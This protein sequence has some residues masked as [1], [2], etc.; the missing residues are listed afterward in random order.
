MILNP[1]LI[2]TT[3]SIW[4][5]IDQLPQGNNNLENTNKGQCHKYQGQ[6]ILP[7]NTINLFDNIYL[8]TKDY[9]PDNII[10]AVNKVGA[11]AQ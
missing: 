8:F 2:K 3:T 7:I 5:N 6:L 4:E 1:K 9:S 11:K 10:S